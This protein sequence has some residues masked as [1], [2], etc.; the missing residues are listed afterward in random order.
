MYNLC[1]SEER[2]TPNP[3]P[4]P[5]NIKETKINTSEEVELT[6]KQQ[7]E[8][9]RAKQTRENIGRDGLT[10]IITAVRNL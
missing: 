7:A 2:P 4:A 9:A 8:L 6:P 5:V 1:M 10:K 3:E